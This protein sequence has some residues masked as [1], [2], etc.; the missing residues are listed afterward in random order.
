MTTNR[1]SHPS[2][3]ASL[4]MVSVV[5][6]TIYNRVQLYRPGKG[7]HKTTKHIP[8]EETTVMVRSCAAERR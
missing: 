5:H 6:A 7:A 1:Y 3:L 2:V 4:N 8:D